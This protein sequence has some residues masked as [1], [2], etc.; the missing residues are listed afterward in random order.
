MNPPDPNAATRTADPN[1]EAAR[2]T[3]NGLTDRQVVIALA[4]WLLGDDRSQAALVAVAR[5]VAGV[6]G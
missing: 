4:A 3:F 6:G 5:R 2:A 1:L